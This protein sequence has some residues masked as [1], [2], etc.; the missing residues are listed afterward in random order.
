VLLLVRPYGF[1]SEI[2]TY[3]GGLLLGGGGA[4]GGVL[5]LLLRVPA[6][7]GGRVRHV[8]PHSLNNN[9]K[10]NNIIMKIIIIKILGLNKIQLY[11]AIYFS[12][13]SMTI[14]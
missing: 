3:G 7:R 10:N 1:S 11:K 2:V 14:L 9:K 6:Q 13:Q 8:S 12:N 4:G 5:G